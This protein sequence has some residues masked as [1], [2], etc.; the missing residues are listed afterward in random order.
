MHDIDQTRIGTSEFEDEDLDE[1]DD[2][3]GESPFSD[4]EERELAAELL[5][6]E[7]EDELDEFLGKLIRK[8]G[9]AIKKFGRSTVGRALKRGLKAVA[10]TALPALGD[11]VVPGVGGLVAGQLGKLAAK[12]LEVEDQEMMS[13]EEVEFETARKLVRLAGAAA[14]NAARQPPEAPP[15]RAAQ[16]AIKKAAC[17]LAHHHPGPSSGDARRSGSGKDKPRYGRWVRRGRN[18][19]LFGA[20]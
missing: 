5:E 16:V 10:K 1:Y 9:R 17:S 14:L 6:V 15:K 12:A 2:F 3:D 4:E 13:D 7:D 11:M 8:A 20:A 19:V 18:I